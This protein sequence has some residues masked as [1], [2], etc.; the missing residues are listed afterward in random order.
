MNLMKTPDSP[1]YKWRIPLATLTKNL[2]KM[3]DFPFKSP[4]E[5]RFEK[6]TLFVRGTRSPYVPDETL[7]II[8]RFFPRFEVVDVEA[9]HWVTSE[10]PGG[11]RKGELP[12]GTG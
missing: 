8:G 4:D 3:G 10:N 9:G 12:L 1:I 6:P 5:A 2:D 7:P 11:F